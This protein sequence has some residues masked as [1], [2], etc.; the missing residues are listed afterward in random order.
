MSHP[1]ADFEREPIFWTTTKPG[2]NNADRQSE[3]MVNGRR[4]IEKF[5]QHGHIG[6]YESPTKA[7]GVRFVYMI[8]HVGHEIPMV[9]TCG[10]S[11]LDPNN[12]FGKYQLQK[13][14]FLG[15]FPP[16][17]CVLALLTNGDLHEN[18]IV[19]ASLLASDLAPC[20]YEQGRYSRF[21]M[22]EHSL[23]EKMA[24][25]MR[26]NIDEAERLASYKDS[27]EKMIEAQREQTEKL[28]AALRGEIGRKNKGKGDAE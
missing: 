26:H 1:R 8:T 9:L 10:A 22:C 20:R 24:R 11:H 23:A 27:G 12:P 4:V 2:Y 15:W 25:R 7:P 16:E 6:D 14:R 19:E 18:H 13:A 5:P 17:A 3:R 28:V 21:D